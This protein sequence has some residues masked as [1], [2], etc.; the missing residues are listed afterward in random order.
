[1]F[2]VVSNFYLTNTNTLACVQLLLVAS[3]S[4]RHVCRHLQLDIDLHCWQGWF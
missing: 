2:S 3:R 1:M 4:T